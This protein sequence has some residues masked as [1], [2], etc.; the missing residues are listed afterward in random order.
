MSLINC[1]ECNNNVSDIATTCPHCGYPLHS[2]IKSKGKLFSLYSSTKTGIKK[3]NKLLRN[4]PSSLFI[5]ALALFLILSIIIASFG[6]SQNSIPSENYVFK[7]FTWST[8]TEDIIDSELS[9][10][11]IPV[12]LSDEY[13]YFTFICDNTPG[14]ENVLVYTTYWFEADSPHNIRKIKIDLSDCYSW[15]VESYVEW[16]NSKYGKTQKEY[17][18]DISYSYYRYTWETDETNITFEHLGGGTLAEYLYI[19]PKE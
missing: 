1:P 9:D 3:F 4:S 12:D 5:T 14:L 7:T 16:L 18:T 11:S 10:G 19:S 17:D 15:D 6:F 8:P 2:S 13:C